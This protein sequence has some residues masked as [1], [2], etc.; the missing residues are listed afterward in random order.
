MSVTYSASLLTNLDWIRLKTGD[1]DTVTALLQDETIN[2]MLAVFGYAEAL[3]QCAES[4][5]AILA[6]EPDSLNQGTGENAIQLQFTSR[7]KT[8]QELVKACRA[9]VVEEPGYVEVIPARRVMAAAKMTA[10]TLHRNDPGFMR[11][12]RSR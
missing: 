6:Q 11:D 12:F 5:I 8:L 1:T 10:Q 7:I 3:A 2:A 9:G 4:I